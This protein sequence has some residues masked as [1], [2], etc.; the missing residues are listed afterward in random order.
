MQGLRKT[1]TGR[2]CCSFRGNRRMHSSLELCCRSKFPDRDINELGDVFSR[3]ALLAIANGVWICWSC[4]QPSQPSRMAKKRNAVFATG[5]QLLA[6]QRWRLSSVSNRSIVDP[7]EANT[8]SHKVGQTD[9][10]IP[11]GGQIWIAGVDK[12]WFARSRNQ[13]WVTVL[14]GELRD[15]IRDCV[16]LQRS[17]RSRLQ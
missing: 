14:S 17:R 11:D 15:L 12:S 1:E 8:G 9:Y 10:S 2:G 3:R 5:V 6:T 16:R 13:P 4:R 7:Q